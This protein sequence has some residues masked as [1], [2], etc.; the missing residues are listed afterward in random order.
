[1]QFLKELVE[2][3]GKIIDKIGT[4]DFRERINILTVKKDEPVAQIVPEI[5]PENGYDIKGV[6]ITSV[7]DR[8]I[9]VQI[10]ENLYRDEKSSQYCSMI[11][12]MVIMNDLFLS[13]K[14]TWVIKGNV[15]MESANVHYDQNVI[16]EGNIEAGM[17]VECGGNLVVKGLIENASILVKGDLLAR[18]IVGIKQKCLI[19]GNA[20]FEFMENSR[21][22]VKGNIQIRK[23]AI[24]SELRSNGKITAAERSRIF[25]GYLSALH[26][27]SLYSLGNSENIE[28]KVYLAEDFLRFDQLLAL[29]KRSVELKARIEIIIKEISQYIDLK[30][31]I[32]EELRRLTPVQ[33]EF[34]K[35]LIQELKEKKELEKTTSQTYLDM[36]DN[37]KNYL[38]PTLE[39]S[40]KLYSNVSIIMHNYVKKLDNDYFHVKVSYDRYEGM[41]FKQKY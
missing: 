40:E 4:I 19:E 35:K 15:S 20:Y 3:P 29:K 41:I 13:V 28:T 7:Y 22:D 32:N 38:A 1:V 31:N 14:D 8:K 21:L 5:K 2:T 10:G 34:C 18:G 37:M 25:G 9:P 30:K 16:V 12:G 24:T 23:Y 33:I 39:V 27:M 17:T 6:P 26:G 36:K 11:D